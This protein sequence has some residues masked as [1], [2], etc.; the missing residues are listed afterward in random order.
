VEE[1]VNYEKKFLL[2]QLIRSHI[3]ILFLLTNFLLLIYL[4][5]KKSFILVADYR[6]NVEYLGTNVFIPIEILSTLE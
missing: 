4:F 5:F 1:L 6:K 2:K 3:L